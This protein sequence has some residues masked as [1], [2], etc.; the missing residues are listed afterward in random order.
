MNSPRHPLSALL[1]CGLLLL[2]PNAPAQA[3]SATW[4]LNPTSGD[5]NTAAN[6][7]PATVPNGADD[8]ATFATSDI[9][10]VDFSGFTTLF[11]I[12][13]G[14]GADAFTLDVG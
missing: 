8:V 4:N 14:P 2:I 6:W 3:G 13:F 5:W 12:D 9:T 10:S 11:G 7:T 1:L